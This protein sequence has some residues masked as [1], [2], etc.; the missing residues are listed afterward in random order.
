MAN[1]DEVGLY[2]SSKNDFLETQNLFLLFELWQLKNL[3][4]NAKGK[5][6][7]L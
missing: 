1:V 5:N 7:Y 2:Q 3:K 4:T 6:V